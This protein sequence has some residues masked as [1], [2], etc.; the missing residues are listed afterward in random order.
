MTHEPQGRKGPGEETPEE[1]TGTSQGTHDPLA[2]GLGG[3]PT[4]GRRGPSRA[5]VA[6]KS[7][8]PRQSGARA[9]QPT[10]RTSVKQK[11]KRAAEASGTGARAPVK[12]KAAGKTAAK[13]AA[14]GSAR[15]AAATK[16]AAR[17]RV[18]K[19]GATRR[20]VHQRH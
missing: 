9:K 14:G 5:E 13:K 20:R 17:K 18:T 8:A 15:K 12:K 4:G 2:T 7:P 1:L 19:A 10:K 3:T 16:N 6:R 11:A